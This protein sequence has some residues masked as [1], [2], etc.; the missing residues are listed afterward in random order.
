MSVSPSLDSFSVAFALGGCADFLHLRVLRP[1]T[2][3]LP[4]CRLSWPL[5][6][7]YLHSFVFLIATR[8]FGHSSVP[9]N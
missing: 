4:A 1:F 2:V 5:D 9:L 7:L 6:R 3:P 8:P